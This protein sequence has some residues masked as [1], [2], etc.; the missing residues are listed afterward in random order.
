MDEAKRAIQNFKE[1][2]PYCE[3]L[4]Y[5]I[6]DKIVIFPL[7]ACCS[8]INKGN[9]DVFKEEYIIPQILLE[10]ARNNNKINAIEYSSLSLPDYSLDHSLYRNYVFP[11]KRQKMNGHCTYLSSIFEFTEPVSW[12]LAMNL[13]GPTKD[14][15]STSMININLVKQERSYNNTLFGQMEKFIDSLPFQKLG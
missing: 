15:S 8:I 10:W 3:W 4:L 6:V 7:I 14:S 11:A 5:R 1:D 13:C 2:D 9:S 12:D